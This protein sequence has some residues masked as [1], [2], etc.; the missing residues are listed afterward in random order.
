MYEYADDELGNVFVKTNIRAKRIIARKTGKGILLVV[1]GN[2]KPI[3]FP[4]VWKEMRSRLL[5]AQISRP[6]PI[7]EDVAIETFSFTARLSRIGWIEKVQG[8]LKNRELTVFIPYGFDLEAPASQ[9]A[10]KEVVRNALRQEAKKLLTEKTH[11]FAQKFGLQINRIK[12]NRSVSRWGSCSRDKN[13]CFSF[14]LLLL[15]ERYI[16]YVVLHELAHTIEMNHGENFWKLLDRFCGEDAK[17]VSRLVRKYKS[18]AYELLR[19]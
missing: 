1:P 14:Y 5:K 17:A 7:T 19:P 13:I 10:V 15:P 3:D 18:P 6:L 11:T 4:T 2:F 9:E 16:D 8:Q 12:I